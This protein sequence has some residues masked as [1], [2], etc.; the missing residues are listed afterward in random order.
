MNLPRFRNSENVETST[1]DPSTAHPSQARMNS[2]PKLLARERRAV[3]QGAQLGP[4]DLRMDAAA[5]AAVGAG[6]NVFLVDEFKRGDYTVGAPFV[7]SRA[8]TCYENPK[9][10][11]RV[12]SIGAK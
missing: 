6:D 1:D 12:D 2:A 3:A 8:Y 11:C 7:F 5:S 4:G 10:S 9:S